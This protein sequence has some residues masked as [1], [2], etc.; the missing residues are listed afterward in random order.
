MP[1]GKGIDRAH[2]GRLNGREVAENHP[3]DLVSGSGRDAILPGAA[4][5]GTRTLELG[6][7]PGSQGAKPLPSKVMSVGLLRG[8]QLARSLF[9]VRGASTLE[10]TSQGITAALK[11]DPEG[12]P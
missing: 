12:F 7:A 3:S 10:V 9:Q 8:S 6:A 4:R 11:K 2:L 5:E 1:A